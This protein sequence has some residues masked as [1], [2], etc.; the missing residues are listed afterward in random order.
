LSLTRLVQRLVCLVIDN[1]DSVIN[2]ADAD[3]RAAWGGRG[4]VLPLIGGQ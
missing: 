2:D 4:V 3:I 1:T